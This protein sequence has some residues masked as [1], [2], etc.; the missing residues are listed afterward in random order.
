MLYCGV[1]W[2]GYHMQM[3]ELKRGNVLMIMGKFPCYWEIDQPLLHLIIVFGSGEAHREQCTTFNVT[4][5][6][7]QG[8]CHVSHHSEVITPI[9]LHYIIMRKTTHTPAAHAW[10]LAPPPNHTH[11]ARVRACVCCML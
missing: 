11:A 9:S 10:L 8:I 4:C 6:L 3:N 5:L 2:Q 7:R 1:M